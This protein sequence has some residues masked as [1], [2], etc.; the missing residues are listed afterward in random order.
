MIL[1]LVNEAHFECVIKSTNFLRDYTKARS[2]YYSN[3][4][5]VNGKREKV[6]AYGYSNTVYRYC[7]QFKTYEHIQ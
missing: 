3:Y 6:F 1:T 5:F 4:A 7:I 2:T